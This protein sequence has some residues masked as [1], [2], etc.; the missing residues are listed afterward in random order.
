MEQKLPRV[1]LFQTVPRLAGAGEHLP[2]P[3]P[4]LPPQSAGSGLAAGGRPWRASLAGEA[5]ATYLP[6]SVD[7]WFKPQTRFPALLQ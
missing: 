3:V 6:F 7:L 2:G 4:A 5:R 1:Q